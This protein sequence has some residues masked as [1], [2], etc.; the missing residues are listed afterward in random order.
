MK[1]TEH[2]KLISA[3]ETAELLGELLAI[4]FPKTD[5]AVG[6]RSLL[7]GEKVLVRWLDG[8]PRHEVAAF[9]RLY[10][11]TAFSRDRRPLGRRTSWLGSESGA[12]S[13]VQFEVDAI[14]LVRTV[15]EEWLQELTKRVAEVPMP[16]RGPVPCD[17]CDRVI[18]R[19]CFLVGVHVLGLEEDTES[20]VCSP[21]CGAAVVAQWLA[22]P[23]S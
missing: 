7:D 6:L 15:S 4:E 3:T 21:S 5:F 12:I 17:G 23:E 18:K 16:P 13:V 9:S 22:R 2:P 10:E 19:R 8:P 14:E 20:L 1:F 11:G